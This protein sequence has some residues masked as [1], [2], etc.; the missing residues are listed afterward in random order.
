MQSAAKTWH[1]LGLEQ[2]LWCQ[3]R[4]GSTFLSQHCNTIAGTEQQWVAD[5][6]LDERELKIEFLKDRRK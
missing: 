4:L 5:Y 3:E 2:H 6:Q 1:H